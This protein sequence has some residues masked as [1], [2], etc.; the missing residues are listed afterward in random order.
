MTE[1]LGVV[2]ATAFVTASLAQ[3]SLQQVTNSRMQKPWATR[4]PFAAFP[5]YFGMKARCLPGMDCHHLLNL[6]L[7]AWSQTYP[8]RK[9]ANEA[10]PRSAWNG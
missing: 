3:P 4:N 10:V 7:T 6:F 1:W 8:R 9:K 5:V 2:H